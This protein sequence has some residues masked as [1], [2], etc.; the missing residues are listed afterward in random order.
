MGRHMELALGGLVCLLGCL[1]GFAHGKLSVSVGM[2]KVLA[3]DDRAVL[4]CPKAWGREWH[5]CHQSQYYAS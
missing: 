1:W 5:P 3:G 2:R 4:W